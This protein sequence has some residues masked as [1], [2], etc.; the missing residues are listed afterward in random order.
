MQQERWSSLCRFKFKNSIDVR[1]RKKEILA[2]KT[3]F[4]KKS[5]G[6][7]RNIFNDFTRFLTIFLMVFNDHF[8]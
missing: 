5:P 3:R 2:V 7:K 8:C 6:K 1:E 4:F